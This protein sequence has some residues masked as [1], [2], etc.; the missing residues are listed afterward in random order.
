[1]ALVAV[2]AALLA[3]HL[4]ASAIW[5]GGFVAIAVVA[6]V[7]RRA[8]DPQQRIAFFRGLGRVYGI[9]GG[10][11]LLVALGTG[12]ALVHEPP[13][14]PAELAAAATAAA[15]LVVTAAGVR[16][17]RAMTRL[18]RRALAEAGDTS[19]AGTLRRDAHAA[20]CLRATIGLLTVALVVLGA[21]IAS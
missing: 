6:R 16:Q 15:L 14:T 3:V 10:V 4:L 2:N 5:V 17:A 18:R 21:V 19:L 11:S 8:L 7:A 20:A 9:V 13:S 1:M 12:A